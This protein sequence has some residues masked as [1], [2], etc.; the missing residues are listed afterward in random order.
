[1]SIEPVIVVV[2]DAAAVAVAVVFNKLPH[3]I[4]KTMLECSGFL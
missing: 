4:W 3:Y 2:A 1:M